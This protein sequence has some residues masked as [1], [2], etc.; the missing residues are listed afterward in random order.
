MGIYT[1]ISVWN[2]IYAFFVNGIG[3]I[4]PQLYSAIV[5]GLINVPLSI[6]FAKYLVLGISGV[7]LGTIVSLF[8]FSIIGPI[9]S[10]YI[11]NK[12]E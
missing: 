6:Y 9:Q 12:S 11:L 10:Y 5:A 3:R 2:N 1:V 8:L 4:K 7:I